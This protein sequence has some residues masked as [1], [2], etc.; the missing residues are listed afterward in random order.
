MALGSEPRRIFTLVLREGAVMVAIGFSIGLVGA[1][2]IRRAMRAQLFGIGPL[3][4]IV[5]GSVALT[6]AIVALVACA[7]PARRASRVDPLTA[8]ADA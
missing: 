2:A 6:L 3:D 8:L 1:V 5:L 4:P 7:V